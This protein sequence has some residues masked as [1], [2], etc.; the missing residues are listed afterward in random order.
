MTNIITTNG[1]VFLA[2]V[3]LRLVDSLT[4]SGNDGRVEVGIG[5]V[6]RG[7]CS[8]DWDIRE[9]TVVCQM[10][11]LPPASV[12]QGEA[13]FGNSGKIPW[14]GHLECTGNESSITKCPHTGLARTAP[15][16]CDRKSDAGVI[17]GTPSS[18]CF[19]FHYQKFQNK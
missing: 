11:G 16:L 7:I 4:G 13:V 1:F 15:R 6:W 17:C 8:D 5:G 14:L 10:L 2:T 19:Y 3:Q 12:A 9:A 18:A